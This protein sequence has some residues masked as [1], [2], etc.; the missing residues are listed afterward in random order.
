MPESPLA[1]P[2][3]SE[4]ASASTNLQ[5]VTNFTIVAVGVLYTVGLLIV[6]T[7]LAGYG[8]TN[9]NLARAEYVLAG[10]LWIFLTVATAS[11][12][13]FIVRAWKTYWPERKRWL[14]LLLVVLQTIAGLGALSFAVITLSRGMV[15][16]GWQLISI[17]WCANVER[18]VL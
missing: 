17:L 18:P 13:D 15:D 10:A 1:V 5:I 14:A 4:T 16:Y 8:V 7:D 12:W 11:V 9:L 3:T 6:N 2:P